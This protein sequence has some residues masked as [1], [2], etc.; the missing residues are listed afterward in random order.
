VL[1]EYV[2]TRARSA[3]NL[4]AVRHGDDDLWSFVMLPEGPLVSRAS[5][6]S[7]AIP[8]ATRRRGLTFLLFPAAC[9]RERHTVR[10]AHAPSPSARAA[11]RREQER[12]AR[13]KEKRIRRRERR[14]QR[15]EEFRLREQQGLSSPVTSEYSSSD[16][17]E[18]SD[19]GRAF[20][21][22]WEPVPPRPE[23]R[24]RQKK[25]RLGRAWERLPPGSLRER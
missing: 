5:A 23:P 9:D 1:H 18:E 10:P 6:F 17:K 14:E 12:A 2:A 8:L 3:I 16:E 19:G 24:R 15:S 21:E 22:R 20:P 11:Q 4:K 25:Q 13:K 7:P